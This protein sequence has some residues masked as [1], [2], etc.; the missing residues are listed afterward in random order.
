MI[1]TNRNKENGGNFSAGE[2][3]RLSILS[4]A[5]MANPAFI[6][7]ELSVSDKERS[8]IINLAK[9]N[10]VGV[11]CSYHDFNK[12]PNQEEIHEIYGKITKTGADL[13]KLIFTPQTDK[14]IRT[15]LE[16]ND[17]LRYETTLYTLFGMGKKG[18]NTRLLSLLLGSCLSYCSLDD[19]AQSGL[20]QVALED[21]KTFFDL[22]EKK[23]WKSI[24]EKRQDLISLAAIEFNGDNS[25]SS[26]IY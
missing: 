26:K 21:M 19:N 13:V 3:L 1:V 8:R 20:Y 12:T 17:L 2:E 24:K 11:I 14:D 25:L 18:Q 6:D 16:A 4:S 23:G 5:I 7:I 15:I 9:E 10:N 22:I